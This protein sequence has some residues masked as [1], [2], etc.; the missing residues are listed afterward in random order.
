MPTWRISLYSVV[1]GAVAAWF[2]FYGIYHYWVS[3]H[4]EAAMDAAYYAL[5][6]APVVG[7]VVIASVWIV[8]KRVTAERRTAGVIV[9]GIARDSSTRYARSE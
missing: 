1:A 6:S 9:R 8:L 5:Y 4:R 3:H 2:A 7:L